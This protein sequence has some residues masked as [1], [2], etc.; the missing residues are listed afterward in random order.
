[1]GDCVVIKYHSTDF[2]IFPS[3]IGLV[4]NYIVFLVLRFYDDVDDFIFKLNSLANHIEVFK[5]R[6]LI[7]TN[8]VLYNKNSGVRV[9][10]NK[11]DDKFVTAVK[12]LHVLFGDDFIQ[13]KIAIN[14]L[15]TLSDDNFELTPNYITEKLV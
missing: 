8:L 12:L 14:V 15:V 2:P 10:L 7:Y 5:V 9:V 3:F 13:Q 6:K 11:R 1:M 4:H